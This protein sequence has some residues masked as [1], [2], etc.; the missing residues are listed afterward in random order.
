M[1]K[2]LFPI[3]L[4]LVI[5]GF[6]CTP[7][8]FKSPTIEIK[9]TFGNIYV[10]LYPGKA[11]KTVAAFLS[12]IDSGYFKEINFYRVLK[13]EDQPS[14]AF[15]SEIIQGGLWKTNLEKQK[16]IPGIPHESTRETGILHKTGVISLARMEAG[17]ASTEFFIC[18]SDQPVYDYGGGA[19]PEAEKLGYSAFGKVVKGFE[20]VKKIHAQPDIATQFN[21]PIRIFNIVR[22]K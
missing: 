4:L 7:S 16:M 3:F 22:V 18:L 10:E 6:N 20:V 9:T 12:Y 21:P 13:K 8:G 5:A 19:S 15:K 14:N 11:P 1:S 2:K 17:T